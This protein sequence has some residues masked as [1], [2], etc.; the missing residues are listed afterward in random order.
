M[1][2]KIKK[3]NSC[4]VFRESRT[5]MNM[6]GKKI[7]FQGLIYLLWLKPSLLFFSHSVMFDSLWPHGPR[8]ASLPCTSLSSRACSNSCPLSRW[9]HPTI[10][11]SVIPFSSC[12]Q[13]FPASRLF[14]M[15]QLFASSSQSIGVSTS[16]SVPPMSIQ[17]WFPLRLTDLISLLSR[18]S[19][20]SSPTPQFKSINFSALS[21]LH[22]PSLTPIYDY[23][24][25]HS[26]DYM[27]LCW[28]SI[29]IQPRLIN[30]NLVSRTI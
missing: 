17:G 21:L 28:Q 29:F 16:A 1:C 22:S 18:D 24:K 3:L 5:S 10:S 7:L 20:E 19:R 6:R 14:L 30:I 13:P 23:W 8:H 26:F 25:S 9:W 11:S 2:I 12:P 4:Y 15:S 27:E